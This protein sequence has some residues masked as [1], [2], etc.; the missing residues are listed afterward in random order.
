MEGADYDNIAIKCIKTSTGENSAPCDNCK[1][2]FEE[3]LILSKEE[4]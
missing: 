3:K 4:E 1:I 2:T